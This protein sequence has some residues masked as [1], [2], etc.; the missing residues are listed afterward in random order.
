M[1]TKANE[2]QA[3]AANAV[4]QPA[5]GI[6]CKLPA[7]T[8]QGIATGLIAGRTV[9]DLAEQYGVSP[10]TVSVLRQRHF[11]AIPDHKRRLATKLGMVA[12]AAA[13]RMAEKLANDEVSDRSLPV[14]AGVSIEKAL[15]LMNEQPVTVVKHISVKEDSIADVLDRL[16][17]AN[18]VPLDAQSGANDVQVIDSE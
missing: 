16:P 14:F 7:E 9:A 1:S 13:D 11:E 18:A 3:A 12:E 5:K 15:L 17:R 8:Y 2:S 6:G 10:S 4:D